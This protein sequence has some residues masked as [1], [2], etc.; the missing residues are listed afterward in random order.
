MKYKR[1][2]LAHGQMVS[3]SLLQHV[4]TTMFL[5]ARLQNLSV[6]WTYLEPLRAILSLF[7]TEEVARQ[8]TLIFS[9]SNW[10]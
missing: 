3:T 5:T 2:N 4:F 6:V 9:H 8:Q 1:P 10:N 7:H